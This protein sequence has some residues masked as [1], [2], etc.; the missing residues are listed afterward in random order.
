MRNGVSMFDFIGEI[1]L[2]AVIAIVI[3]FAIG[4]VISLFTGF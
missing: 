3:L 4:F 2:R 1:V